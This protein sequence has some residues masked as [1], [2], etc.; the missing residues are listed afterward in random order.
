MSELTPRFGLPLLASGQAQKEVTHNEALTLA[1]LLLAPVVESVG[2]VTAP[3]SPSPGKGWVIGAGATGAWTGQ[4][5]KLAFW[6]VGGW[7]FVMPV[8]GMT[9]WSVADNQPVRFT[10]SGWQIGLVSASSLTIS[11]NQ[12]VGARLAAIT[13]PTGG[14]TVD[15]EAR[16]AID[17]IL[18][19]L[20][21]HGLIAT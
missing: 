13:S 15:A 20:R 10:A 5:G 6:T 16:S 11:G 19:R 17:S 4:D 21:S 9:L 1:D 14:A 3:A 18:N 7:R 2:L 8:M 12:V